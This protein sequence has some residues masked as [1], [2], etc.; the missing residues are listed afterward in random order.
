MTHKRYMH[1]TIELCRDCE[2]TGIMY[3]YDKYDMLH[4]EPIAITCTTCESSGRV[5]V[6]KITVITV[7]PFKIK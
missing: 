1:P 5:L 4:Q 2:G 7:E 3:V 6:S